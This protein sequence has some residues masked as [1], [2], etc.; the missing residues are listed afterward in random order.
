MRCFYRVLEDGMRVGR[1][2]L[3]N[4]PDGMPAPTPWREAVDDE[5]RVLLQNP[6]A[7]IVRGGRVVP[8]PRV[9]I[10]SD[11]R[12]L[13]ADGK[14]A[15]TVRILGDHFPRAVKVGGTRFELDASEFRVAAEFTGRV[16]VV[17]DDP[18]IEAE[19]LYLEAVEPEEA[20]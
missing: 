6:R 9:R 5:E 10:V 8:K 4:W 16:A 12:V 14:D 19:P 3:R 18:Y 15:V 17:V 13:R 11:R 20:A 2:E 7:V 1:V